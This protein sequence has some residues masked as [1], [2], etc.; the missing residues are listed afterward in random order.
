MTIEGYDKMDKKN[1]M[2]VPIAFV[3]DHIETLFEIDIE[4]KELAD[5]VT[6]YFSVLFILYFRLVLLDLK[7]LNL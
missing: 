1:L 2:I 7:E 6:L 3:S 4:Y 5:K